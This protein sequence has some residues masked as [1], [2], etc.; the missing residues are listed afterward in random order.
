MLEVSMSREQR[1]Q[2][3]GQEKLAVLKQYL[4][5]RVPI[6]KLCEEHGLAPSQI[7]YW[8][9]QLFES[10]ASVFDRGK[11][12]RQARKVDD[13]KD[14][15]IAEL[16]EKLVKKNEVVAELMEEHVQLKKE[17]GEL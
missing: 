1:K 7:Y 10:G 16:R 2:I 6:S 11:G 4:V 5:D 17:L 13:A 15:Q 14:R 8:Q 9:S 12:Q 3:T